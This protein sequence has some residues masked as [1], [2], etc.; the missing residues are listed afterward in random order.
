M[1]ETECL[2]CYRHVC[3]V[4]GWYRVA[5][6]SIGV[7]VCFRCEDGGRVEFGAVSHRRGTA[8]PAKPPREMATCGFCGHHGEARY[9]TH[10]SGEGWECNGT[11]RC[12]KRQEE[13]EGELESL[14]DWF[15]E[16]ATDSELD[17]A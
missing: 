11:Y 12:L 6:R 2:R 15:P 13:R 3:R 9:M 17:A 5:L 4:C 7:I 8:C 1:T 14:D 10:V 16:T